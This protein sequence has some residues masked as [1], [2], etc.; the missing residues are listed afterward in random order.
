MKT[1]ITLTFAALFLISC[2]RPAIRTSTTNNPDFNVELLFEN[3]GVKVWRFYDSGRRIYYTDARGKTAWSETH[4]SRK[5][6][7]TTHYA[8]PTEQ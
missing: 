2:E 4:S 8:V 6:T 7:T 3:E 1:I 5:T